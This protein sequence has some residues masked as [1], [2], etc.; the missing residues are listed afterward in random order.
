MPKQPLGVTF[1]VPA[2]QEAT[3]VYEAE[4]GI[5][6]FETDAPYLLSDGVSLQPPL[7]VVLAGGP[8]FIDGMGNVQAALAV[9]GLGPGPEPVL[10][11]EISDLSV[12]STTT[13]T[14]QLAFTNAENATSHEYRLDGGAASTLAINKIVTGLDPDTTSDVEV[15]G[16]NSAGNGDW[17]NVAEIITQAVPVDPPVN[18][19][20]PTISGT[21]QVG[22]TLTAT[23]GSWTNSPTSYAY[24][25]Q[26][27]AGSWADISGATASTYTLTEDDEG[28]TIRVGI[29]ATNSGGSSSAAY[30]DATG[31]IEPVTPPIEAD[32]YMMDGGTG[33]GLT[34][35][36]AGDF[37]TVWA[38]AS[39]D[40]VIELVGD[41]TVPRAH[42]WDKS[43]V[44][45]QPKGA[46]DSDPLG[47]GHP[48][49]A[50]FTRTHNLVLVPGNIPPSTTLNY[51][52]EVGSGV[53]LDIT[54]TKIVFRS[55]PGV[56]QK[57]E[58]I[59][60]D[61]NVPCGWFVPQDSTASL[62]LHGC[63]MF[64]GYGEDNVP[65]D[66]TE[67][68]PEFRSPDPWWFV[69][70]SRGEI[71]DTDPGSG[72]RFNG[73]GDAEWS[74]TNTCF[75]GPTFVRGAFAS[76]VIVECYA[77]DICE[78]SKINLKSGSN[79]FIFQ[80]WIERMVGDFL[81]I[82]ADND[83]SIMDGQVVVQQNIM[84]DPIGVSLDSGNP[85]T[86]WFQL[87]ATRTTTEADP[88]ILRHVE[89][90]NNFWGVTNAQ[91]RAYAQG[92][93]YQTSSDHQKDVKAILDAPKI[94][95]NVAIGATQK[96]LATECVRDTYMRNNIF[97]NPSWW[98][99]AYGSHA[100]G[101]SIKREIATSEGEVLMSV[102]DTKAGVLDTVAEAFSA[103]TS[104]LR[105]GTHITGFKGALIPQSA[106]FADPSA[107]VGFIKPGVL[108]NKFKPIGGYAPTGPQYE[109][110]YEMITSPLDWEGE[111]PHIGMCDLI[112]QPGNTQL[113]S[114]MFYLHGGNVG[115]QIDCILPTGVTMQ[116]Y[117]QDRSTVIEAWTD[118]PACQV[119]NYAKLRATTQSSG[120]DYHEIVY[121]GKTFTWF[122]GTGVP[123]TPSQFLINAGARFV[124]PAQLGSGVTH[125]EFSAKIRAATGAIFR[126]FALS[127]NGCFLEVIPN[128]NIRIRVQDSTG[129]D[130]IPLSTVPGISM[131]NNEWAVPV[132]FV[133]DHTEQEATVTINNISRIVPFAVEGT[134]SFPSARNLILLASSSGGANP[135]P[136]GGNIADLLILK[137]QVPYKTV[138]NVAATANSDPWKV[139]TD[140]TQGA[141]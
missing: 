95:N 100:A 138:S 112:E 58:D 104:N 135:F 56:G 55:W 13:T 109:T 136:V 23:A 30:S 6:A 87:Y 122:V 77:H 41:V 63:E 121:G 51:L 76:L 89:S 85:H 54:N 53:S 119:G 113:D 64:H 105:D 107:P 17:S 66:P 3:G 19:S 48:H 33:D 22:E 16:V 8:S 2:G 45:T 106:M 93:F 124:D 46:D 71:T 43:V 140:F 10:P 99:P 90:Q 50:R 37:A 49:P 68:L 120:N 9:S 27:N 110:L 123:G 131:P 97:I 127:A 44:I 52:T 60:V 115:D 67:K 29:V 72:R 134:G 137:N 5:E 141:G 59:G 73:H 34:P 40:D 81:R 24:Q 47:T 96:A 21:E 65:Y 1:N 117:A 62:S 39:D 35:E 86:D 69:P 94:R 88:T 15:R 12:P 32:F 116:Q 130:V 28:A 114:N 78:F 132:R 79:V 98:E 133:I 7:P 20:I 36:T 84:L 92:H 61:T 14:A 25:W 108:F 83:V 42:R 125:L 18:T 26:R 91:S 80:N 31:E 118:S 57:W 75:R 70:S 4:S 128:G 111:T 103:D 38:A 11:G 82:S 129:T 139:G 101:I 102:E 126:P 74:L